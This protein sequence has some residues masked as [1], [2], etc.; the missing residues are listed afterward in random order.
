[1]SGRPCP[2]CGE[3]M[4]WKWV[5]Q[6]QWGKIHEEYCES[7]VQS[8]GEMEINKMNLFDQ[9]KDRLNYLKNRVKTLNSLPFD[10]NHDANFAASMVHNDEIRFLE[11]LLASYTDDLK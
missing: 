8:I 11:G 5:S 2:Q 1:M 10:A 9:L 6:D 4:V 3:D 7:C